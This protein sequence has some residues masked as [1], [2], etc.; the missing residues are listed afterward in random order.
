M[1][2]NGWSTSVSSAPS[3]HAQLFFAS[4]LE[5]TEQTVL[6]DFVT[7]GHMINIR[8]CHTQTYAS[9]LAVQE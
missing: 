2:C 6:Q 7:L 8:M 5:R 1:E 9:L 3:N 4:L